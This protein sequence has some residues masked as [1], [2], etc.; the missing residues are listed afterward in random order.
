M[1]ASAFIPQVWAATVVRSLEK[2]LVAKRICNTDFTGDI[3][4]CGSTVHFA[5]LADPAINKYTGSITYEDL[6]SSDIPLLVDQK[7]YFAFKVS[8]IDQAQANVDLENSQASRAAYRLKDECDAYILGK[9]TEAGETVTNAAMNSKT[10]FS[11]IG[12]MSRKLDEANVPNEQKW[13]VIPPWVKL[14]LILAGVRFSIKDGTS[15]QN[16]VEWTR[17]LGCDLYVS[18]NVYTTYSEDVPT[19]YCLGGSR[20]A[21]AFADSVLNTRAMEL[22]DSFDTG[23][24]G[25]HVFGAKVI[26]PD[27]LVCGTFTE[28]AET[29]I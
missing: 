10:A 19:S 22:E 4:K 23:V 25:L 15:Q 26:K 17:E 7:N 11:A 3:K 1:S 16:G 14:K 5:G 20:N 29:E 24:S 9:Y 18:N 6:Q 8:D 12:E 27:E 2:N 21:I 13:I 28:A